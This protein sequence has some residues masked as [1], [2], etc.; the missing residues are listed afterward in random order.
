[1]PSTRSSSRK[2]QTRLSFTPLSSSS[3]AAAEYPS[4]I[5]ERAAAVR[6]YDLSSP[7]KK[8]RV[9]H[10]LG[11]GVSRSLSKPHDFTSPSRRT[12]IAVM[13]QSTSKM[14]GENPKLPHEGLLTP[15]PSSQ[16]QHGQGND[17]ELTSRICYPFIVYRA[18]LI[19][20][21]LQQ[22]PVQNLCPQAQIQVS[23]RLIHGGSW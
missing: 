9:A 21:R 20:C 3:P 16:I 2:K 11:D 22:I 1:M 10:S 17:G 4:Q 13:L 23:K 19:P 5:Q 6:Y 12:G 18:T 7:T 14:P 8:R 15:G